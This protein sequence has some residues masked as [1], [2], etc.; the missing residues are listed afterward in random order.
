MPISIA[1]SNKHLSTS[2]RW[3][4]LRLSE[5]Y[6]CAMCMAY[7]Q[8]QEATQEPPIGSRTSFLCQLSRH[9]TTGECRRRAKRYETKI[10]A[11]Q[12]RCADASERTQR[13]YNYFRSF[14]STVQ[15][16]LLSTPLQSRYKACMRNPRTVTRTRRPTRPL[17]CH[18]LCVII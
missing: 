7:I 9:A 11:I 13:R 18:Q 17:A 12:G 14:N 15:Y 2:R 16:G 10:E 6:Y 8:R 5:P 3:I 1:A 4:P